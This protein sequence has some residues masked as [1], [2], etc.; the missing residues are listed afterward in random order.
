MMYLTLSRS[1]LSNIHEANT[2]LEGPHRWHFGVI[3]PVLEKLVSIVKRHM[4]CL[5]MNMHVCVYVYV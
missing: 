5:G 1:Y 2:K 4:F 3:Q